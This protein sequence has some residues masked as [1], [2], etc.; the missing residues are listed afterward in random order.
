MRY[1]NCKGDRLINSSQRSQKRSHSHSVYNICFI[2]CD[3]IPWIAERSDTIDL[4]E[5]DEMR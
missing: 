1:I 2:R 5:A 4:Q 3:R